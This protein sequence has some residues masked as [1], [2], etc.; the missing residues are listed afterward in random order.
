[1]KTKVGQRVETVRAGPA[2]RVESETRSRSTESA[3]L[4]THRKASRLMS[5]RNSSMPVL[6][7]SRAKGGPI[8]HRD[9]MFFFSQLSVMIS[10]GVPIA[11]AL[12]GIARQADRLKMREVL[13]QVLE[14]VE[15]GQ[16]LSSA[17]ASHRKVFPVSAVHLIRAGET[18]G[19]L[20]GML[21]RVCSLMEREYEMKK[22][23]KAAMTYPIVMLSL[24]MLT[25][26]T[27]FTFILPRFRILYAGKED[28]LPK[29]TL[30]LLGMGDFA[31]NY[32]WQ[33]VTVAVVLVAALAIYLRS[34]PGRSFF[35]TF[36]LS[37][38]VLGPVI[39]K[40]SLARSVRTMGAL[41]ESGVPVM[42]ALELAR[43]LSSNQRLSEAWEYVRQQVE[44]GSR[45]H[46]GMAG[47]SWFPGTLVQMTAMGESGGILDAVLVKVG[48]FYDQEAE[49]SVS[50]ATSLIE[51][52]MVVVVG[53]VV[54]FIAMSIMLPIFNM[55]KVVH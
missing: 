15:S 17:L 20:P 53:G 25:V 19:D 28:V 36:V 34:A 13:L 14:Q 26:I 8:K 41:L 42:T 10:A 38:P 1:M 16:S 31:T 44:E 6:D 2:R 18:S 4:S 33:I 40:F 45:I 51:P 30:I 21:T 47:Q 7:E 23:M 46:D 54:G 35:D 50:E 27:L 32:A 55:S 37:V 11:V 3:R 43:D 29:P 24:A 39:R 49:V 48:A 9:K 12:D 5:G 22:K 52:V